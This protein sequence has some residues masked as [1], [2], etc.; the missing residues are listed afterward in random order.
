MVLVN[1]KSSN[2]QTQFQQKLI[3]SY[4]HKVRITRSSFNEIHPK[5]WQL[6]VYSKSLTV[7]AMQ[8]PSHKLNEQKQTVDWLI[9]SAVCI[10]VREGTK[11][12]MQKRSYFLSLSNLFVALKILFLASKSKRAFIFMC[13]IM[14]FIQ[15]C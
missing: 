5:L 1:C 14:Q 7:Y 3:F 11:H 12:I 8:V 15:L 2:S 4:L 6:S 13:C 10:M 9:I